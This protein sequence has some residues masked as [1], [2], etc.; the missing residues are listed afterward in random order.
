MLK[1]NDQTVLLGFQW[2]P[3]L[4]QVLISIKFNSRKLI[5]ILLGL[6]E[7][8]EFYLKPELMALSQKT[9]KAWYFNHSTQGMQGHRKYLLKPLITSLLTYE[10]LVFKHWNETDWC[11]SLISINPRSCITPH[12]ILSVNNFPTFDTNPTSLVMASPGVTSDWK[13]SVSNSK[14]LLHKY[15]SLRVTKNSGRW[16]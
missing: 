1:W 16:S 9:L 7:K 15:R 14:P 13:A 12:P 8:L 4:L 11:A 6:F 10:R 3:N 5:L 2:L